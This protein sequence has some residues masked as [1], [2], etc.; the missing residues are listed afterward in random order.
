LQSRP[1][2]ISTAPGTAR[3][4]S[5]AG[6]PAAATPAALRGRVSPARAPPSPQCKEILSLA[7]QI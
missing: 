4:S 6:P 5:P 2:G 7:R 1:W 3:R